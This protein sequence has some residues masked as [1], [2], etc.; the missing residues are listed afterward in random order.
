MRPEMQSAQGRAWKPGF[1]GSN[2]PSGE[3]YLGDQTWYFDPPPDF[4]KRNMFWYT[5]TRNLRHNYIIILKLS[6]ELCFFVII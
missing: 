3:I 1:R 5:S 2:D 4:L 6:L